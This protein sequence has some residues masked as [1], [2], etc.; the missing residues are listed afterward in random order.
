MAKYTQ[1]QHRISVKTPLGKDKLY[2]RSLHGQEE[3]SRLFRYTLELWSDDDWIEPKSIVGKN[4]TV[5]LEHPDGSERY[6]HGIVSRFS[7]TGTG[8]RFSA[9]RAEMVPALWLLTRAADCRIFQDKNIPDILEEVFGDLGFSDYRLALTK[10]YPT[11]EYC[12]QYRETA[13]N[14]VSR[15]MEQYGIFYFFQHGDGSHTMVLGDDPSAYETCAD[16]EV[17]F[18]RNVAGHF[19]LIT[20][21]EHQFEYRPGKWCHT[22]YNFE[23]PK[24]DLKAETQSVV[25]LEGIDRYEIFDYPGEYTQKS[26]G[27]DEVQL[28][29]EEEEVPYDVVAG[30]SVCRSFTPG[31]KFTI[32]AHISGAETGKGYVITGV[33]HSAKIGDYS[34]GSETTGVTYRNTFRCVPDSIALRPAR[35]TPKPT[36]QGSQPAVVVGPAGEE[37]WPDKY[38]RVKVQFFWDRYGKRDDKSSCW[39]RCVQASAGRNWGFMSIP[40]VGQEVIVSYLEGDPDRPV[41]TGQVYNAD[42]MPAYGL[43][44]E[45]TKTYLKTNSSKGGDGFNEVRFEDKAGEEQIFVHAQKDMDTRVKNDHRE[46]V[47]NEKH[48]IVQANQVEHVG[49]DYQLKVG[50]GKQGGGNLDVV[51]EKKESRKVGPDGLHVAVEGDQNEEITGNLS[52]KIKTGDHYEKLDL[53]NYALEAMQTVHVKGMQVL[54]EA[55]AGIELKCGGSSI[56]ITP[57]A[58]FVTG[59]PLVN[60]NSGSGPPVSPV[61]ARPQ[62]PQPAQEAS[63]AQAD[64]SQTGQKSCD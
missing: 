44:D 24:T 43:P 9:Y 36:I 8:D 1:E 58:I 19:D 30:S 56:A 64:D 37:I 6:F 48:V 63:P 52:V 7:Y 26:E 53:G 16:G 54:I 20:G 45:K 50:G 3:F 46:L 40:R 61:G 2:L 29:M 25:D 41:I 49:G 35:I 31:G 14:F 28:R 15:L 27:D 34:T 60:I 51:V 38:G 13:F 47:E 11:R 17:T 23:T 21:W 55:T 57:A 62:S 12:V 32:G 22:D 4:V 59:G 5:S 10:S 18:R 33:T 42:Q 39:I